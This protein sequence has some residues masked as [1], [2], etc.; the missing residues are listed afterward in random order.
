MIKILPYSEVDFSSLREEINRALEEVARDVRQIVE[1]VRNRGD[2]ALIEYSIK[3]DGVDLREAGFRVTEEEIKGAYEKVDGRYIDA[4]KAAISNIRRYHERQKKYSWLDYDGSGG[5]WGQLFRPL[6]RVGIYVP[7]GTAAYPSSVLMNGI[8]AKV[9]G[10]EEIV[11]VSPPG[12]KG[13]LSP[14]T[15]VAAH[16]IGIEEIYKL[17]GAHGVAAL[18]YGTETIRPVLKITGPGNVYVTAAKKLVY[19]TVDIDMLAGP[20]EI[21]IVAD[22]QAN[23]E[24]IAA[25]MLSQSEHDPNSAA[26]LATPD[27]KLARA[28]KREITKQLGFLSRAE[29]AKASLER[30]G[31]I[32]I[33][34]NLDEAF[35]AANKF[36]PEHLEIMVED[37][38]SFVDRVEAAG[39]IFVGPYT[40]E[41]VGDYLGGTNHI[42]P[43][44]G[45]AGYASPLGV[46]E[47]IKS[48]SILSYSRKKLLN[49]AEKIET[50]A[51]VEGLDAHAKAVSIRLK[52]EV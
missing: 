34:D 27:E 50:L 28:V 30:N 21:F 9:A 51:M 41:P 22:G 20:S 49:V 42:L 48:T 6:K 15:L 4:L 7:G 16:E 18:A 31:M 36:A 17:G 25:D 23:P 3:F 44:G 14:H 24:Y 39:A 47:F 29:I 5:M 8:P 45:T 26:L 46:E 1:G 33:T 32:I 37:S 38:L 12:K 43:T 40:P 10:V 11:M 52:G 13:R 19:G 2:E 35:E